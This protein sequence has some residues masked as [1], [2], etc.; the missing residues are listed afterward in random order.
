MF[1]QI[2]LYLN[3]IT[4]V[5]ILQT[6]QSIFV[7]HSEF[8]S[9]GAWEITS[10]ESSITTSKYFPPADRAQMYNRLIIKDSNISEIF[11]NATEV[12]KKAV[13]DTVFVTRA[14]LLKAPSLY[15]IGATI[16]VYFFYWTNSF[17]KINNNR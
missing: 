12:F 5:V 9:L 10:L 13:L 11:E 17:L 8:P 6:A 3:R 1:I 15:Y 14:G 4:L 7:S 2:D 16:E